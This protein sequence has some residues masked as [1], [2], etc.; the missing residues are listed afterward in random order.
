MKAS[1]RTVLWVLAALPA[2]LGL[3]ISA[4]AQSVVD[5]ANRG[6]VELM[7]DDSDA[8]SVEIA[9][10]L[11][12]VIDDGSTRRVVP[13]LGKGSLQNLTDLKSLRGMDMA[14]VQTDVLDYARAQRVPPSVDTLTYIAKLYNEEFHLLAGPGVKSIGDLAGKKVDLG[15][16]GGGTEVTGARVFDFLGIK[17]ETT[18]YDHRLALQK[19]ASGEIAAMAYVGGKPLALFAG[20]RQPQGLHFLAIPLNSR[21]ISAYVPSRL[22]AEDYPDLVPANEAVDTIAVGTALMVTSLPTNTERYRNIANFTEAF[23]TQF[24]KLQEAPHHPKWRE[25]NLAGELPNWRRFPPAESWLKR[26]VSAPPTLS[27][28]QMRDIFMKFLDE[29]ARV[30]GQPMTAQQKQ[31]LF[32]QFKRWQTTQ[33]H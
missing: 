4:R 27:D 29:R 25:V 9:E 28:Q 12:S 10:D 15:P 18:N 31:D 30:S 14:I 5:R 24:A 7:L 1:F 17:I 20:L 22:T 26:N 23:F 8:M 33:A 16:A 2:V 6:A 3:A 13:V 19:L 11:A 21:L 32:D